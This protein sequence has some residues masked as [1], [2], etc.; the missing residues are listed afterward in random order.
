MTSITT[1][2][3]PAQTAAPARTPADLDADYGP[4]GMP[5][6]DVTFSEVLSTLNPLQYIPIVGSIY[7]AV[8]GDSA[9]PA[10]QIVVSTLLGGPLGLVASAADA[11]LQQATGKDVGERLVSMFIPDDNTPDKQPP[12]TQYAANTQPPAPTGSTASASGTTTTPTTPTPA[13]SLATAAATPTSAATPAT[14][15]SAAA[16]ATP[17][18][19]PAPLAQPAAATTAGPT[20]AVAEPPA[21]SG[22]TTAALAPPPGAAKPATKPAGGKTSTGWTLADYRMF[23]GHGMPPSSGTNGVEFHNNPVPLQASA[24]LPG[25]VNRAPV[26]PNMTP[27]AATPA[28][29]AAAPAAQSQDTWVSQAM[30]RGLDRYRQMMIQQEQQSD[31]QPSAPVAGP[32]AALAAPASSPAQAKQ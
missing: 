17:A 27:G 4:G 25:E 23:A 2:P 7:R 24:P 8:T 9:P 18:W 26:V 11:I 20:T 15:T 6:H 21:T 1:I 3:G 31:P 12:A 28:T 32:A 22:P 13:A 16:P 10:A 14:P 29:A 30:M 5:D 19:G